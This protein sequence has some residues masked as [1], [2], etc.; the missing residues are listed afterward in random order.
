MSK[1]NKFEVI[2]V[3]AGPAGLSAGK[4]LADTGIKTAIFDKNKNGVSKNFYSGIISEEPIKEIFTNFFDS[5]NSKIMAPFERFVDQYRAY[6]LQEDSFTSFNVQNNRQ[7]SYIVL[8][9]PFNTWLIKE[10]REAGAEI[11]TKTA[12]RDLI[13][14]NGKISG[15][16]TDS[17]EYSA[18]VVI[19][20]EGINPVLTKNSGLRTGDY[21]PSQ[22]F[23]FV[24][25]TISLPSEVIDERFNLSPF[26]GIS[27]KLFTQ[28]MFGIPSVG[29]IHTNHNSI[30]L[31]IGILFSELIAK[32]INPNQCLEK[33]KEHSCIK[34]LIING[35]TKNYYSYIL[36]L[37]SLEK[38]NGKCLRLFSD[39]CLLTGGTIGALDMFSWDLPTLA[40][41]SG[42]A[43][44][45]TVLKAKEL[46]D[47]TQKTLL[48]YSQLLNK[49]V[50]TEN[51]PSNL[52]KDKDE[53]NLEVLN[54]LSSLILQGK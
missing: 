41:L 52:I 10:T 3:G 12:V 33:L 15:V 50:F 36:P 46:N 8:R 7:N 49:S 30:S 9:D 23:S 26:H 37:P 47:Y 22:I 18:D 45:Q 17:E 54:N 32:G 27:A 43:A 16:K 48:Y 53:F 39:G 13:I 1:Q 2:I 42:K 34:P 40:I 6:I 38:R 11:I 35:T 4:L 31:G 20:A 44:A 21:K 24:E 19:I 28:A 14:D 5:T 29:Y 25:E 51:T